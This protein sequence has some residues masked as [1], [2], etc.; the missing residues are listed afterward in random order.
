MQRWQAAFFGALLL[1]AVY[2]VVKESS[3]RAPPLRPEEA[4]HSAAPAPN[5]AKAA[6]DDRPLAFDL[7]AGIALPLDEPAPDAGFG[8][9]T[10]PNGSAAPQLAAGAPKDI[11]F[12]AILVEY[13]GVQGAS[14]GARSRDDA[15]AL[16]K[17]LADE[18]KT[19]FAAAVKE[20][21]KGSSEDFG[22]IPRGILE[23]GPEFVLFNLKVGEVS[24]PTDSPRG[25][26]IF[27]RRE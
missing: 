19:D 10:L 9:E 13:Q 8:G 3:P 25:F 14:R 27:K 24:E 15:L 12:G 2:V 16:A 18:A 23:P 26:Y 5:I 17:K 7:D 22:S 6:G 20:G 1:L 4:A 11:S 21:D